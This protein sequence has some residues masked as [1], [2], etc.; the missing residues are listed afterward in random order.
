MNKSILLVTGLLTILTSLPGLSQTL[1]PDLTKVSN[2]SSSNREFV[3]KKDQDKGQI[4]QVKS[5]EGPGVV[6]LEDVSFST[7]TLE[8]DV[9]GKDVMQQSFVGLAFHG[10]D[11]STYEAIYFRPFNF[12]STEELRRSHSVQYI[13]LPQFD[14]FNLRESQPGKYENPLPKP[15]DPNDW[16][17]VKITIRQD[18][19]QV[20]VNDLQTEVLDVQPINPNAEGKLG[21]WVGNGSDG[22]FANLRIQAD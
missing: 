2:F 1:S 13:F 8:F 4:I 7:G 15:V 18:Q 9:K 21:F 10:Q 20:Y 14:W 6:W 19:I 12:N 17:H 16:F 3:L 5:A 22:S 11:D